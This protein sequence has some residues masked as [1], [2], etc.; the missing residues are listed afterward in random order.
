[1]LLWGVWQRRCVGVTGQRHAGMRRRCSAGAGCV[2]AGTPLL[3]MA[4]LLQAR[5]GEP[6]VTRLFVARLLRPIM[7]FLG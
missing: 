4:N 2:D 3:K 5:D 1:M 6:T 7:W